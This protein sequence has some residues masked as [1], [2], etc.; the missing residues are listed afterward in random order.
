MAVELVETTRLW[1][2][3]VAPITAEQ[4]EAVGGHLI[5]RQYSEPR[6]SVRGGQCVADARV[7]LARMRRAGEQEDWVALHE[8]AHALKGIAGNLGLVQVVAHAGE[9]MKANGFDLARHWRQHL[10]I[11]SDRLQSGEQALTARGRWQ[12]ARGEDAS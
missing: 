10:E 2:R 9:V 12:P 1:A 8:Q 4:V 7:A 11:L 3:T 6:W 5:T